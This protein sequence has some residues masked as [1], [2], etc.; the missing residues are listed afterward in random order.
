MDSEMRGVNECV[1]P[2]NEPADPELPQL[3]FAQP[4]L[5]RPIP[6]LNVDLYK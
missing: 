1:S 5:K 6:G 4:L 3:L 2:R